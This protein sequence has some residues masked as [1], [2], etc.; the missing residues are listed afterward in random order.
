MEEYLSF[1]LPNMEAAQ[2]SSSLSSG[3]FLALF[4]SLSTSQLQYTQNSHEGRRNIFVPFPLLLE[5]NKTFSD[6]FD[7]TNLLDQCF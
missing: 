2:S 7:Y 3:L 6:L 1:L 4:C 5:P